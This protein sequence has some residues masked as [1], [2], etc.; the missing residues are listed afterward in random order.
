MNNDGTRTASTEDDAL[1][2]AVRE[3]LPYRLVRVA[4]GFETPGVLDVPTSAVLGRSSA[5][6]IQVDDDQLSR[7]HMELTR[8]R[9]GRW[10][11]EDLGSKNGV[12]VNGVRLAAGP[13]KLDDQDVIRA[14][15]QIIVVEQTRLLSAESPSDPV[16]LGVSSA[17]RAALADLRNVATTD[18]SVLIEGDS[19]VG[20]ELAARMIHRDSGRAGAFVPVNCAAIPANL[21]ESI[22]FGHRKG[23]F[24]GAN[25]AAEG[26]FGAADG[27]TLFLDE[28]AEL[29]HGV[30]AKLLRALETRQFTPLGSARVEQS[31]VRFVAA[32]N[33]RLGERIAAGD[34]RMDLYA[35]I[36]GYRIALPPL[37]QRRADVMT[38]LQYFIDQ[39]DPDWK[40]SF[41]PLAVEALVLHPWPMNV[42][43]LRTVA[44]R[45]AVKWRAMSTLYA[46]HIETV[47][48]PLQLDRASKTPP[49]AETLVR[50][51]SQHEGS[52]SR[53][54]EALSKDRRQVYRWL[55][56][57]AIDPE[58]FRA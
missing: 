14:G 48:Q 27:G 45:M 5:A 44:Q 33:A 30:Q 21:A 24:T 3:R 10:S 31:D 41:H 23:A 12:F 46:T 56:R 20:K 17:H 4:P 47:L 19:G 43:E 55:R 40:V 11:V 38:L 54:A 15:H 7:R 36:A 13:R 35:R 32:T 57:H 29:P 26:A 37:G 2:A 53:V 49:D 50:L 52:V 39:V 58:A 25:A 16:L 6:S 34:F 9:G 8:G 28:L 22:L 51:L 42:R 18:L 1:D